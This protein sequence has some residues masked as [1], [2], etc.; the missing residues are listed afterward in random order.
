MR[1]S[2][3]LALSGLVASVVGIVAA[4]LVVLLFGVWDED[5]SPPLPD[6]LVA[7]MSEAGPGPC[8]WDRAT[9]GGQRSYVVTVDGLV[10]YL[11]EPA[12]EQ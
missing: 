1:L 7:C 5:T 6:T 2:W 8:W 12:A 3:A 4:L 10:H 11:E 9:R